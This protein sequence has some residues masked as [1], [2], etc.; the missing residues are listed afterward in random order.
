MIVLIRV[1]KTYAIKLML[2]LGTMPKG[3]FLAGWGHTFLRGPP[4]LQSNRCRLRALKGRLLLRFLPLLPCS[5][6]LVIQ[7]TVG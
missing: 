1:V 3:V 7:L 2:V 5:L 4:S 6:K